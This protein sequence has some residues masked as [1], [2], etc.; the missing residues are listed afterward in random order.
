MKKYGQSKTHEMIFS[1]FRRLYTRIQNYG[2][3]PKPMY[4]VSRFVSDRSTAPGTPVRHRSVTSPKDSGRV[5][6]FSKRKTFNSTAI[7]GLNRHIYLE[8]CQTAC[9]YTRGELLRP[10]YLYMTIPKYIELL[11]KP[12]LI[13]VLSK[14]LCT[15]TMSVANL[16]GSYILSDTH[17]D[18]RVPRGLTTQ[19][20]TTE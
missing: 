20:K 19:C 17:P 3:I 16:P 14:G 6:G 1:F 8:K 7:W 5:T 9:C 2:R 13:I 4:F 15:F 11:E 12:I 10:C 18:C